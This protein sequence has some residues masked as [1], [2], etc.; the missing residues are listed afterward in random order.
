MVNANKID[1][2]GAMWMLI[3]LVGGY[4]AYKLIQFIYL[5]IVG[6]TAETAIS[7]SIAVPSTINDT[8]NSTVNSVSTGFS[9][10]NTAELVVIGLIGLV[11][12]VKV[13]WPLISQY[14]P[15]KKSKGMN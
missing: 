1:L 13:F 12:I 11:V 3:A 7:G 2:I 4:G 9:A 6:A 14:L 5:L 10:F 8:I 15:S